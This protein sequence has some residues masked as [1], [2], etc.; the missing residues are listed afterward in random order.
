VTSPQGLAER[1]LQR[2]DDSEG[3]VA[4]ADDTTVVHV[5]WAANALTTNGSAR[6]R[7]LTVMCVAGSSVGAASP[8]GVLAD[9]S[10]QDLPSLSHFRLIE[11]PVELPGR[12][13]EVG[14]TERTQP[15]G[16]GDDSTWMAMPPPREG[17]HGSPESM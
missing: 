2:G 4:V 5:R 1:A 6:S 3:C 7:R 9:A 12:A 17:F 11:N 8:S 14:L 10:L 16:H 13:I 15:C